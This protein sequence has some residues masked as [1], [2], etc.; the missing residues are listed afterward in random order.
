MQQL[1]VQKADIRAMRSVEV[2]APEL[3][4]GEAR[5]AIEHFSL[6]TN[7]VTY[8][9][10]GEVLK[11]WQFFP[12]TEAGSGIVPA[13]GTARVVE[14]RAEL[15][16]GTR[17][18]GYFPMAE[19]LVIRPKAIAPGAYACTQPHRAGLAVVYNT[20]TVVPEA[21]E[22]EEHLRAL[23]QPLL[24]TSWLLADWLSDN[25]WFGAEQI[26]IGS[27]SS[28]T[29]LGLCKF[30]AEFEER[31]FRIIGLTSE[32]NRAFVEAAGGC[33][34]VLSYDEIGALPVVPSVYVDMAGNAEVKRA[35][36]THLGNALKHSAA[37]GTSHW[38]AF[39]PPSDLPG[40]KPQFF[41]APAQVAKRREEWGPGVVEREITK[42]WKRLAAGADAWLDVA[43]HDGLATA[44]PVWQRLADGQAS[45]R[46]GH[47]IWLE[48][49]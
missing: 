25:R 34:Q 15:G 45:P 43:V 37:V 9:A 23:L 16:E 35:L 30:L 14:S 44:L 17:L 13:W 28:K 48:G 40:P 11:Y 36:H 26:I 6:T 18:Y 1:I 24:A 4:E 46:E 27:A 8:A 5:L 20:Y 31:L 39:R 2:L 47:I 10:T 3:A 49:K 7:N 42:G 19:S 38:E 32:R 21:P 22:R 12:T 41:F 33:D 29:G